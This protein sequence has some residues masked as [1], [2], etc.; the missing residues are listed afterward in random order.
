ML[1]RCKQLLLDKNINPISSIEY[2]VN[3]EIHT[4]SLEWIVSAF[5]KT[6]KKELFIQ[7]L[8]EVVQGNKSDI[9]IFFQQMGQLVLMSSLS[10]NELEET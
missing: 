2:D 8:E 9:E 1:Q 3:G 7:M 10:K 4:L 6:E 5:I